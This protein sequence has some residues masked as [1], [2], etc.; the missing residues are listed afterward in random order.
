MPDLTGLPPEMEVVLRSMQQHQ[1]MV[2]TAGMVGITPLTEVERQELLAEV[3]VQDALLRIAQIQA[4]WD[5][6]STTHWD[7]KPLHRELLASAS[8]DWVP[9]V[10]AEIDRGNVIA[11][12]HVTAGLMRALMETDSTTARLL[13]ADELLLLLISISTERDLRPEF[14]SDT[15]TPT[16]IAALDARQQ[17]MAPEDLIA[18]SQ[19][20]LQDQAANALFN[21]PRKI[22]CLK[23]DALDFW[24]SPWADRAHDSLGATPAETFGDATGIDLDDF[25]RLGA[26][27][28]NSIAAGQ[29]IVTLGDLTDN[30]QLHGYIA[31]NMTLDLAG[32]REQLAADRARGNV[33]LQRYTFTRF[34][35]LDLGDRRLLILRAQ[36]A[37][38]RFFG[39]AAQFDVMAAFGAKGD[40]RS[41][42]R[43][44]DAVKYQFEDIVGATLARIAARS[45]RVNEV[46][47]E[48]EMQERWTEKKGQKP[49]VC[50]W[51][52]RAG[53]I[54]VLVDATHHPLNATLAQGLG[55][56]EMYDTDANKILTD[57]K[58]RQF[59]SV[60]R[61]ARRL[62]FSGGR[63]RTWSSSRSWW[64]RT[65][66]LQAR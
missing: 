39:D 14:A 30:E 45:R 38:E 20:E 36:W 26:S 33:K 21:T 48:P 2:I 9:A 66:A 60:M 10:R 16:E 29:T 4:K 6:A 47:S 63:S 57:G 54:T 32:F 22:E 15:P 64:C 24:Y 25:L 49:S 65:P 62:G 13:T 61:L 31:E 17:A 42:N 40:R 55:D 51:A 28:A 58:F 43:F 59:A 46:V 23:A 41:A 5:V 11:A 37:T 19:E 7:L 44:N 18:L 50:D 12:P 52:L 34:P 8:A 35:F 53:P 27:I 3:D 56:G 1:P